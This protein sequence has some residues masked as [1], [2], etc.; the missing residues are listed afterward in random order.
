MSRP[1]FAISTHLYHDHP[2]S[3]DHLVEIAAHGFESVELFANR[4]HLA[5]ESAAAIQTLQEALQD[6]G[7]RVHALH[8]PIAGALQGGQW[9]APYSIAAGKEPA[10]GHA[11]S[12][13]L[14]SLDMA[15][16]VGAGTLVVHL[17]VPDGQRPSPD[18]NSEAAARR[19][20]EEL[21]AAAEIA[22]V[23]LALEVMPNRL[24]AA[25][26]LVAWIEEDLE[27]ADV[28]ICLDFGHAHLA[29]DVV[30]AVETV[31]GHLL[32]THVH[33]NHGRADE[34]LLP[35]EGGIPWEAVLMAVQ[36]VGYDGPLV[37]ELAGSSAPRQVLERA[38]RVRARFESMLTW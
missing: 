7:L 15:R 1:S 38:Q 21:H 24:S 2:L 37:F 27:L 5:Y 32:T 11:V 13:V 33:D 17:G 9:T 8:A 34:H 22:G 30:D 36:K 10:R 16:R 20:I 3:R 18:D 14:A 31:S 4:P 25:E 6:T 12:E 35:F 19:S 26:R 29:G 23:R 28:G